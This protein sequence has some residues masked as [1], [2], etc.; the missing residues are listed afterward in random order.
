[1]AYQL[2]DYPESRRVLHE[3]RAIGRTLDDRW[4]MALSLTLLGLVAHAL[5]EYGEAQS[6][7]RDGLTVWRV[8]GSPSGLAF[9]LEPPQLGCSFSHW[10]TVA[11]ATWAA[12]AF[13]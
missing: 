8:V 12:G 11:S 7:F 5:G 2:G 3:S 9:C 6:L 1:V 10:L 13:G 4:R